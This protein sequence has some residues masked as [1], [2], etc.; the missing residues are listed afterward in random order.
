MSKFA[1][2]YKGTKVVDN[3]LDIMS[4]PILRKSIDDEYITIEKRH[5][6]RP[7]KLAHEIY[8]NEHLWFVFTLRNMDVLKDPIFDF[9]AGTKI[10]V[11]SK[12]NV[13][14]IHYGV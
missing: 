11:P 5:E 6:F 2:P 9:K 14:G 1:S 4:L 8:G 12:K 10:Y 3:H 13:E 7:D